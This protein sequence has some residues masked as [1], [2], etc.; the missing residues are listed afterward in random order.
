MKTKFCGT[1]ENTSRCDL[2]P[3]ND[4]VGTVGGKRGNESFSE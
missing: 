1:A 4:P 3:L 2:D